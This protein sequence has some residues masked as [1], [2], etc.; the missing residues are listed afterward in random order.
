MKTFDLL[1]PM[2]L[3]FLMFEWNLLGS[4]LSVTISRMHKLLQRVR[5]A[6]IC[7]IPVHV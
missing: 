5:V 3:S 6:A 1:L 7:Q 2:S 4:Y